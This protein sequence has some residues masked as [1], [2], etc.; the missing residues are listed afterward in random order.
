M[1]TAH[2]AS[3]GP[4]P[5][6]DVAAINADLDPSL[7][8]VDVAMYYPSN[9]DPAHGAKVTIDLLVEGFTKAKPI[10]L[11]AG[12][13]LN[14]L[15]LRTGHLH[16]HLFAVNSTKPGNE[17]PSGRFANMYV[18]AERRPSVCSDE[19]LEASA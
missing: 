16:P 18:E 10:F 8:T 7:P 4:V 17:L 9:L 13:Q 12:V 3:W 11:A 19:A 1:A 6:V 5:E 15:W 14:L 2:N